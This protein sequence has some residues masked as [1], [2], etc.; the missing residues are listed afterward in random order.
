MAIAES[1]TAYQFSQQS[2]GVYWWQLWCVC[3]W[4]CSLDEAFESCLYVMPFGEASASVTKARTISA[5][6]KVRPPTTAH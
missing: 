4:C 5:S 2:G 3:L 6:W 1:E